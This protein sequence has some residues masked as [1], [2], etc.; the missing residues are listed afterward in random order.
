MDPLGD[1]NGS[2]TAT[3]DP[4]NM[5]EVSQNTEQEPNASVEQSTVTALNQTEI[6][7]GSRWIRDL[8]YGSI[9]NQ[10]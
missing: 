5:V 4:I 3:G 2:N 1:A 9:L 8:Q 10:C 6:K 7:N